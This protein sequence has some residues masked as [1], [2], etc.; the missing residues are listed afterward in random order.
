MAFLAG[1]KK[2]EV[3]IPSYIHIDK[4]D[5]TI[6]NA[7]EGSSSHD[8]SDIWLYVDDQIVGAFELPATIPVRKSGVVNLKIRAG[9]KKN[10][11]ASTRDNYP[12]YQQYEVDKEIFRDSIITVVPQFEY[13]PQAIFEFIED[14]EGSGTIFQS[15]FQSDTPMF[16]TNKTDLVFEGKGSGQFPIGSAG[17]LC[18][19]QSPDITSFP[20]NGTPIYLELD[21]RSNITWAEGV[22]SSEMKSI[23]ISFFYDNQSKQVGLYTL[24]YTTEWHKIYLDLSDQINTKQGASDFNITMGI[25]NTGSMI[26]GNVY[27]DNIKLIHF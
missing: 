15:T 13:A 8:I 20:L 12:F 21:F 25:A 23:I 22:T 19:V 18:E 26:S 11:N 2:L 17:T 4:Y 24:P 5:L 1:C 10:G 6:D 27:V 9:I 3:E 16:I 14:F 7:T